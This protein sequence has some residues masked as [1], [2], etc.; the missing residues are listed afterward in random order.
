MTT[1]QLTVTEVG[2]D[3]EP[4]DGIH[5]RATLVDPKHELP[6]V[7]YLNGQSIQPVMPVEDV[8][9]ET[10]AV[11]VA[12]I[13]NVLLT[14]DSRYKVETWLTKSDGTRTP[15]RSIVIY[16][17]NRNATLGSLVGGSDPSG[18][19]SG[20]GGEPHPGTHNRYVG[21]SADRIVTAVEV[22]AAVSAEL[23][24]L[25]VQPFD[26]DGYL[27]IAVD[28]EIGLPDHVYRQGNQYDQRGY[29]D[30]QMGLLALGSEQLLVLVTISL[31]DPDSLAGNTI[32]L[33][34]DG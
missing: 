12:I 9:D 31:L 7:N 28:Q 25:T 29:F 20:G 1:R 13:P 10:G 23:D 4:I 26:S 16:M 11:S 14:L 15:R 30:E 18:G 34:Y 33:R 5:L 19:D 24:T 2:I 21:W 3:G 17:P 32:S 8:S 6:M 22:M 27:F